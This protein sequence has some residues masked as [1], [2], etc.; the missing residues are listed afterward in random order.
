MNLYLMRHGIAVPADDPSVTVDA[1]RPLT[2]KGIKRTRRAARGVR[3]L[4]IP[5]DVILTSPV[6]RARQTAD[7]VAEALG[8]EELVKELSGLAPESTVDHLLFGLTRYQ[9]HRH[10]LLV[11]H[12]PLL[13]NCLSV[14]LAGSSANNATFEFKKGALCC[15]EIDELSPPG[16]CRLHWFLTPKQLRLLGQRLAKS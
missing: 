10:L 7:I 15:I 6:F 5:F 16:L 13:S 9:N 1:Q 14:L 11:G 2:P 12:E 3:R 8:A 4:E